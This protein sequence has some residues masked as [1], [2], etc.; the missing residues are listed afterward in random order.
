MSFDIFHGLPTNSTGH[1]MV[2][3]FIDNF[4]LFVI[5]IKAKTKSEE[6][7][8]RAF[9]HVFAIWSCIPEIVVSD[10]ET[11]LNNASSSD[12]F[13]SF[14]IHHNPGAAHAPLRLLAE[15][16]AIRKSKEFLRSVLFSNRNLEWDQALSL[17]TIALNNTCTV[18]SY[19]PVQLFYSNHKPPNHL[20]HSTTTCTDLDSYVTNTTKTFDK[21]MT[22]VS[23]QRQSMADSR[24]ASI[25]SNKKEVVFQPND[26]VWLRS[27]QTDTAKHRAVKAFNKGPLLVLKANNKHTYQLASLANPRQPAFIAHRNHLQLYTC[28]PDNTAINV[29]DFTSSLN[30]RKR[31][32]SSAI[33]TTLNTPTTSPSLP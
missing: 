24:Q 8:H 19:S 32:S 30:I 5:N 13:K 4:S 14:N 25:N 16:A 21:M 9:L 20:L 28:D 2:Y 29:P 1:T 31:P 7:L 17:A 15:T 33:P 27:V 22:H 6:E 26:L 18:F 3:S 10:N 11:A 12:F 23:Q